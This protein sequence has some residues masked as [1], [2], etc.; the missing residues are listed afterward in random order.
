MHQKPGE[1]KV[2]RTNMS[3][4]RSTPGNSSWCSSRGFPPALL[5][6]MQLFR[7]LYM[8]QLEKEARKEVEQQYAAKSKQ[9]SS[10]AGASANTTAAEAKAS[11][12]SPS[13]QTETDVTSSEQVVNAEPVASDACAA[14]AA[15]ATPGGGK[16]A[17]S[18]ATPR[19]GSILKRSDSF[20]QRTAPK[21]S[22]Q[23][24][25]KRVSFQADSLPELTIK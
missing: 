16:A 20:D 8:V 3:G 2:L 25:R 21:S 14:T 17:S 5:T 13:K 6:D 15:S 18:A 10:G 12:D 24:T 19:R 22:S 9:V 7:K 11:M 23:P 4:I 1:M